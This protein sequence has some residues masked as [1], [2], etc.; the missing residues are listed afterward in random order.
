PYKNHAMFVHASLQIDLVLNK[1]IMALAEKLTH[2]NAGASI[3][4]GVI[5]SKPTCAPRAR[6]T[7]RQL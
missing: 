5:V 7:H 4:R 6:A 2:E 1:L 3:S